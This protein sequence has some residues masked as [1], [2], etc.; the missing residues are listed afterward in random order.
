VSRFLEARCLDRVH[1]V[2][3]PL[4]LVAGRPSFTFGAIDRL[5]GAI[6]PPIG[7]TETRCSIVTSLLK[8][9][10]SGAPRSRRDR[11]GPMIA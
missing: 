2:I 4:I 10:R 3:A 7:S 8:R 5:E 11:H 6:R 1:A 9:Y